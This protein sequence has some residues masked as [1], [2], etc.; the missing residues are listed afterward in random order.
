MSLRCD[1]KYDCDGE[2]NTAEADVCEENHP[3]GES[4]RH[5]FLSRG[6]NLVSLYVEMDLEKWTDIGSANRS[7]LARWT[8][9]KLVIGPLSDYI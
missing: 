6:P 5:E 9:L 8:R 4:R 7:M 3:V 1:G 2:R